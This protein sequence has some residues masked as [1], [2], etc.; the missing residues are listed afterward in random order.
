MSSCPDQ[1]SHC[2]SVPAVPATLIDRL[3]LLRET[4]E[5]EGR[6][7]LAAAASL[8]TDAV[9][10]AEMTA[11]CRG[12]VI[13][14][15]IGKAGWIGQKL[16]ATLAST[17]NPAHF[18]HP[19]EAVHGDLGK[20]RDTDVVWAIS[21]SGRSEELVRIAARLREQSSGLIVITAN[22]DNPLADSA[23]CLVEIGRHPE[24]CPH[25]LA[26]SSSTAVML[27]VGDAIAL[28]AS[29]LKSF[30]AQ[31]FAGFHPG[32]SLG[33]KL[34]VVDQI[35]RPLSRCRLA[36]ATTTIREAM[37]AGS[38]AGRRTGAVMLV[39][40]EGKLSG[41]F[42]DS[43]LAKLL[44]SR[45]DDALDQPIADRM[46]SAPATVESG[47]LLQDAMA[48]MSQRRIS[49]LPV[50]DVDQRPLGLIDITDVVSLVES[51]P[52]AGSPPATIRFRAS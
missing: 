18:L 6:A 33:R 3:R 2:P 7:V 14:T 12:S 30:S 28:L 38:K 52:E 24:A 31:D 49:E 37:V 50:I 34:T 42:T 32:G 47:V 22:D 44:E 8:S 45:S 35:M 25:G 13:V 46:T 40:A 26:P 51:A 15:G 16:V 27:A 5:V 10:A 11:D 41:V 19:A 9:H 48:T 43:D 1:T 29:R 23:D 39:D 4:V 36:A 17:G 21:N 20:V